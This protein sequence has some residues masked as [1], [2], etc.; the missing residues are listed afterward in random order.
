M[1]LPAHCWLGPG[2]QSGRCWQV[3]QAQLGSQSS[4]LHGSQLL[5]SVSPGMHAPSLVQALH[6]ESEPQTWLP[7]RPQRWVAFSVQLSHAPQTHWE[8]QV[9]FWENEVV[10]AFT[11]PGLQAPGGSWQAPQAPLPSQVWVPQLPQDRVVEGA[12]SRHGPQ[13]QAGS[14]ICTPEGGQAFTAPGW[15]PWRVQAPSQE[16]SAP[17]CCFPQSPHALSVPGVQAVEGTAQE[18]QEQPGSHVC[19]PRPQLPH[20]RVSVGLQPGSQA[21]QLQSE[22]QVRIWQPP[23]GSFAWGA[24]TPSPMHAPKSP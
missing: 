16:Q 21:P 9:W 6:L 2:V 19:L 17:Q 3:P 4:L 12:Q 5:G 14:Q 1:M 15:Q 13:V 18:P 8:L 20:G 7:Q 10:H 22:R 24:H 23:Q 11:A